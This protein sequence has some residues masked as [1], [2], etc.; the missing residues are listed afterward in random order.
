LR[1][2]VE[3]L[4]APGRGWAQI[5]PTVSIGVAAATGS[6]SPRDI[7]LARAGQAMRVARRSPRKRVMT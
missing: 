2:A 4:A 3:A 5:G 7:L 1:S 6:A